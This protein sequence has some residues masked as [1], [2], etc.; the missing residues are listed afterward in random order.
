MS[1]NTLNTKGLEKSI[2]FRFFMI[3]S[4]FIF[5]TD[6]A[7]MIIGHGGF[8]ASFKLFEL[9]ASLVPKVFVLLGVFY[10]NMALILP[11]FRRLIQLLIVYINFYLKLGKQAGKNPDEKYLSIVKKEA[12]LNKD[13]F[14]LAEVEKREKE[15]A[16]REINLNI[17]FSLIF[18]V[19]VNIFV[20]G[21]PDEISIT[22]FVMKI[23][24]YD[25]G[26]FFNWFIHFSL[27]VFC[28][29]LVFATFASLS[30]DVDEKIIYP[31]EPKLHLTKEEFNHSVLD[32]Q[33]K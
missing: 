8:D 1:A 26:W 15:I 25:L 22:Q 2:E 23:Y 27:L 17:N 3:F 33:S 16:E 24:D 21:T 13:S 19:L 5:F 32:E 11:V 31:K 10:L 12:L 20:V 29:F 6:S 14:W 7:L 18:L 28:S 30:T 4:C 9:R